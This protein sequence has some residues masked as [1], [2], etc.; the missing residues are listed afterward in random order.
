[1]QASI[2]FNPKSPSKAQ[3]RDA[4]KIS[5]LE[6]AKPIMLCD[7]KNSRGDCSG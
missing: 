5:K 4:L 6:I 3:N 1:M 7:V 2:G